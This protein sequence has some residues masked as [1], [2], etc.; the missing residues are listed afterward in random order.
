MQTILLVDDDKLFRWAL[1]E[2]LEAAG[3]T[4]LESPSVEAARCLVSSRKL[5]GAVLD[6][7]LPDGTGIDLVCDL[8]ARDQ[9]CLVAVVTAHPTDLGR[10]EAISR[11]ADF[12]LDKLGLLEGAIDPVLEKLHHPRHGAQ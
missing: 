4:V 11:G 9:D 1:K 8:R 7:H 6:Y 2:H 12:Y 5:D 10:A 3:F